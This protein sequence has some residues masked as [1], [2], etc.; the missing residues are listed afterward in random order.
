MALKWA[1]HMTRFLLAWT[2]LYLLSPFLET[3][4]YN[5]TNALPYTLQ[6]RRWKKDVFLKHQYPHKR[7]HAVT[8]QKITI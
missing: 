6:P 1:I 7:L 3:C 2:E 5:T 4:L 8:T